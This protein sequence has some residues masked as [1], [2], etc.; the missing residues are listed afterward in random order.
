VESQGAV[1]QLVVVRLG[2]LAASV[3]EAAVE[4]LSHRYSVLQRIKLQSKL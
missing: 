2:E 3:V 1:R 4:V